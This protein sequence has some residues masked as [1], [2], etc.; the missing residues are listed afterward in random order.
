MDVKHVYAVKTAC[1][2]FEN[3]VYDDSPAFNG[4]NPLLLIFLDIKIRCSK[5][6][7]TKATARQN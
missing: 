4:N 6:Y 2:D 1:A 7:K 5:F 3:I